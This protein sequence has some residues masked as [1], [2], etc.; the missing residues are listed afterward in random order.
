MG[1]PGSA[2]VIKEAETET[3]EHRNFMISTV[4][5]EDVIRLHEEMRLDEAASL[6]ERL[7]F[8]ESEKNYWLYYRMC[9]IYLSL[10]R[11]DA[12]FY[13][14]LIA[15]D[16]HPSA[17]NWHVYRA[18]YHYF[19]SSGRD[20]EAVSAFLRHVEITP[21]NPIVPLQ[22]VK[23]LL[24]E[25]RHPL[26]A[27]ARVPPAGSFIDH[28]LEAASLS[29][30][31]T[32]RFHGAAFPVPVRDHRTPVY[33][34]PVDVVEIANAEIVIYNNNVVIVSSAGDI[35]EDLS[36]SELPSIIANH[37]KNNV[38]DPLRR[39]VATA[40]VI[41]DRFPAPNLCHFLLDQVTRLALYERLGVAAGDVAVIGP[42]ATAPFQKAIL[43]Q[44]GVVDYIP[45]SGPAIIRAGRLL[46]S[47]TCRE[48]HQ[49][50]AQGAA[51]WAVSYLRRAFNITS[52][53]KTNRIYISR[54]DA[55][56]R[57]ISNE[58]EVIARLKRAGFIEL[59]A[60]SLSFSEQ[61][62]LFRHASH[63]VGVHGAGLSNIVF[64]PP[65]TRVL[66]F[67]HPLIGTWAY[68]ALGAGIDLDYR[69]FLAADALSSDPGYNDPDHPEAMRLRATAPDRNIHIDMETLEE[70]LTEVEAD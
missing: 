35:F 62:E 30:P 60:S 52:S 7:A 34:N 48:T 1:E 45:S 56:W 64:C 24:A 25:R 40:V 70:W 15:L 58:G 23:S 18:I 63:V 32:G 26:G 29:K 10:G 67:F 55:K 4:L 5:A 9:E 38:T 44:V 59:V 57:K 49:H 13:C 43:E 66:E 16:M 61:A 50:P 27:D 17:P 41:S 51:P 6:F 2:D 46:I 47:R 42:P 54:A 36:I 33:R 3:S 69:P 31:V 12:A 65:G 28:H 8:R 37:V 14:A 20:D 11:S 53:Q 19:R 68:A 22:D 39:D 21:E